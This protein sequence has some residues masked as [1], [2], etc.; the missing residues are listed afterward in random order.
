MADP[1]PPI[2]ESI[3]VDAT[4]A[5][6]WAVVSDLPRM[7]EW[8]PEC[9]WMRVWGREVRQGAWVTGLNRRRWVVWP[10]NS[11]IHLYDAE[12]AIGWTVLEN[13]AR[14]SYHLE[15]DDTGTTLTERRELPQGKS[16]LGKAFGAAFLGGNADH[17]DELRDGMRTTLD[18][19]KRTVEV[20]AD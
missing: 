13:R 4:A 11:R 19:I 8:S 3:R 20:D 16:W 18:R 7:G 17:D 12:R 10:T 14:W 1:E 2:E 6:V 15:P 5:A 9:F